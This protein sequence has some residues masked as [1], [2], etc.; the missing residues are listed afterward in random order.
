MKRLVEIVEKVIRKAYE[1]A[2]D[3]KRENLAAALEA[4]RAIWDVLR[5]AGWLHPSDCPPGYYVEPISDE[6]GTNLWRRQAECWQWFD[7]HSGAWH[8]ETPP[9]MLHRIPEERGL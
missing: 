7:D 1:A 8:E 4:L 2:D 6:E 3:Q 9:E 5:Y